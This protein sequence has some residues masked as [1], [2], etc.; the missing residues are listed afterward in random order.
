MLQ[1]AFVLLTITDTP[2]WLRQR[3]L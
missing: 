1:L 2:S 3:A